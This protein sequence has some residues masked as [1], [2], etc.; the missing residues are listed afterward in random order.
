MSTERRTL[1]SAEQEE[2]SLEGLFRPKKTPNTQQINN[3]ERHRLHHLT[4]LS[5]FRL[6]LHLLYSSPPSPGA[7][8]AQEASVSSLTG[9][10]RCLYRCWNP[11]FCQ[12]AEA[13]AL[14]LV[15]AAVSVF[16]PAAPEEEG[17][18]GA[19]GGCDPGLREDSHGEE[20]PPERPRQDGQTFVGSARRPGGNE[21]A[22]R[23][24]DVD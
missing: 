15:S 3:S 17:A 14:A 10:Q 1:L 21:S 16:I 6:L 20:Q 8:E 4:I 22:A 7:R 13:C 2:I 12:R 18:R 23:E 24:G 19:A 5:T 11:S 9:L